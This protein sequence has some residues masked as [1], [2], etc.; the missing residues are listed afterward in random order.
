MVHF[1]VFFGAFVG[2][3]Y[4]EHLEEQ[5]DGGKE[6]LISVAMINDPTKLIIIQQDM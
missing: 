4:A 5:K 6:V 2:F 1:K 3:F